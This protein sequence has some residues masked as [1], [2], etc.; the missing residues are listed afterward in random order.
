MRVFGR[1]TVVGLT[2]AAA[3][4]VGS[5]ALAAPASANDPMM[6]VASITT[7][8]LAQPVGTALES[9]TS[10]PPTMLQSSAKWKG[11]AARDLDTGTWRATITRG[12]VTILLGHYETEKEARKA[13]RKEAREL[14]GV[15]DGPGC[16]PPFV[17][18]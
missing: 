12:D 10:A 8:T 2:T 16:D 14:N 18:C 15:M 13:G 3:V 4:A 6:P 17:L 1:L 11:G 9:L 7:T 5:V